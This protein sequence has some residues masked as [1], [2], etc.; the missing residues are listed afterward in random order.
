VSN[1]F[2]DVPRT[3]PAEKIDVLLETPA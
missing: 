2:D 3:L 1:L